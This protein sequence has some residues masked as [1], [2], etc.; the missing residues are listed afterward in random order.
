MGVGYSCKGR[1]PRYPLR[2]NYLDKIV[3][4]KIIGKSSLSHRAGNA[5]VASLGGNRRHLFV[6]W[7]ISGLCVCGKIILK[8]EVCLPISGGKDFNIQSEYPVFSRV[9]LGF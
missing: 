7:G 3:F 8:F 6:F 5:R 1:R 2:E 9:R 4:L